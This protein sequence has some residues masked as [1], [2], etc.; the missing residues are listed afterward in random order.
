MSDILGAADTLSEIVISEINEKQLQDGPIINEENIVSDT[1]KMIKLVSNLSA[2]IHDAESAGQLIDI[3]SAFLEFPQLLDPVLC[4]LMATLTEICVNNIAKP[5]PEMIYICIYTLSN[6]RGYRELL[7]LFPNQVE[8]FEPVALAF[9]QEVKS[10][11]VR[12]VLCLW[13]AQLSLVPFDISSI[14]SNENEPLANLL[15]VKIQSLFSSPTKESESASFLLSRFLSRK[16][17]LQ[18]RVE[19]VQKALLQLKNPSE[20]LVSNYLRCLFFLF[21]GAD[22]KWVTEIGR[23]VLESTRHLIE[24]VSAH[25]RLFHMKI[26]Q[27]IGL[28]YLPPRV[29]Q[30]RYQHGSRSAKVGEQQ[31]I[32]NEIMDSDS[33]YMNEDSFF[34]PQE[35]EEILSMLFEGLG[36]HMTVVRWSASKGVGRIVERLPYNDAIQAI[37]YLFSLFDQ[38]D[39]DNLIHGSCLCLAQFSLRGVILPSNLPTV[40]DVVMKAL[41]FDVPQ[42]SHTVAEGVRDSG[43]FICWALARTYDGKILEPYSLQLSQQLVNVFLFDR[44]VNIRRSA[45]A[46]FQENVGRHGKFPHG[47]ELIHIADFLTV[48]SKIGCYSRIAKFVA[49]FPEYSN[50]II[51]Y[52]VSDRLKHWDEEIRILAAKCISL[53]ATDNQNLITNQIIDEICVYCCSIDVDIKHGGFEALGWLLRVKSIPHDQIAP[54][55]EL[56]ESYRIDNIKCSFIKMVTTA[57]LHGHNVPNFVN[58][59]NQWLQNGSIEV[60]K[61]VVES[62]SY[63]NNNGGHN[64]LSSEFYSSLLTSLSNSGVS[65]A[66]SSFPIAFLQENIGMV[67]NTIKNVF[68]DKNSLIVSK[69]NIIESIGK[70]TTLFDDSVLIS[71]ISLGL[72]DRTITKR[73]DEGSTIRTAALKISIDILGKRNIGMGIVNDIV[74]LCLDRISG[75]RDLSM[76]CLQK[77]V[78]TTPELPSK[79]QI[80]AVILNGKGTIEQFSS[81]IDIPEF[82]SIVVEGLILCSGAL[83]PDLSK[84]S[85]NS[86][87]TYI[88]KNSNTNASK[89]VTEILTLYDKQ[90][91]NANFTTSLFSFIPVF[92]GSN[93]IKGETLVNFS[94]E[95]IRITERYLSKRNQQKMLKC[96]KAIAALASIGSLQQMSSAFKLLAPFF[97][98][99]FPNIRE[100]ASS[101]LYGRLKAR[102]VLNDLPFAFNEIEN[103]LTKTNWRDDF[104]KSCSSCFELCNSYGIEPPKIEKSEGQTSSKEGYSYKSLVKTMH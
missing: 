81:L 3:V 39:N 20:R 6:I 46:A 50:S 52:L 48:S 96:G 41:V 18:N 63:L 10:W 64:I 87:L 59:L 14:G 62:L 70:I 37:E 1:D 56:D 7:P 90:T 13:L 57:T 17:M 11:E 16:D 86:L 34:V 94:F 36:S 84:R 31:K 35:V 98:S 76:Q 65:S 51:K 88:R 32:D 2:D 29:A 82:S 74:Q 75:I 42:G 43:C 66:L 28:A 26:I 73:G 60:Q 44:C 69:T 45:S 30:W 99:E 55:L 85:R 47:L 103:I 79:N 21:N 93:L 100:L 95:F 22:R 92:V 54:L 97:V 68:G 78:E 72:N 58:L 67:V 102:S 71:M 15:I 91:T 27:Q 80:Q 61:A 25:H 24:S 77:I 33:L 104:E 12:Y 49:Q 5:F 19:F 53:L 89:V 4:K 83:A 38:I 8:L 101:E 23:V 40:M 9:C